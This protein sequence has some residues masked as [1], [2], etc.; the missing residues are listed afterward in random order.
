[1]Y[2]GLSAWLAQEISK[3]NLELPDPFFPG[4]TCGRGKW[5]SLKYA[6]WLRAGQTFFG[7]EFPFKVGLISS[8]G[9]ALRYA[10]RTQNQGRY[11][12]PTMFQPDLDG[13][14]KY[15]RDVKAGVIEPFDFTLFVPPG[16]GH[17]NGEPLPN[18]RETSD[19]ARILTA[20]FDGGRTLWPDLRT[21]DITGAG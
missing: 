18:V 6:Y 9:A 21:S 12:G 20:E 11:T 15:I 14:E 4:M 8:Y 7:P 3:M 13:P 10:D 1:M 2:Q 17:K 19:P 16:Y 5:P